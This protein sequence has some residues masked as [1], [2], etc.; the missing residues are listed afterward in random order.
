MIVH[1]HRFLQ[2]PFRRRPRHSKQGEEDGKPA[3]GED[4]NQEEK[5]HSETVESNEH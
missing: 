4:E 3:S 2:R 1:F 5:L